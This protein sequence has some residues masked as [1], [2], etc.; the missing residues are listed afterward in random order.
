MKDLPHHIKK[1]NRRIIRSEH[2]E[3]QHENSSLPLLPRTPRQQKKQLKAQLRQ[4]RASRTPLHPT[5]E[6]RNQA[7]KK[8]VP[9]FDR[10]SQNRPKTAKPSRKKRPAI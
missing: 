4:E 9:I 10:L 6:E 2:R 3:E 1:L 7:M 5:P 8:R